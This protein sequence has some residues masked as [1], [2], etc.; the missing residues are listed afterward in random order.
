MLLLAGMVGYGVGFEGVD[1][2]KMYIGVYTP[3]CE[4][5]YVVTDKEIYLDTI[6]S[7]NNVDN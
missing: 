2:G 4:Y 7:K 6:F 5:G 3:T 1:G